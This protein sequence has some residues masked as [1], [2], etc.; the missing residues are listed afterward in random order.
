MRDDLSALFVPDG[1]RDPLKAARRDMKR[2]LPKRFYADA[3]VAPV[4]EGFAI[5]LDGK[6]VHTP[7]RKKLAVPAR[8]LA[9]ALAAEWRGQGDEIDPATMPK[10]RLV[11]SALD[12]VAREMDAVA[13]EVA[14]FAGSDLVCYR[15]A[16]PDSLVEAQNTAWNPVLDFFRER[17]GVRFVCSEGVT[18]VDQPQ[19]SLAAIQRAVAGFG[20]GDG[21]AIKLAALNVMTTLTGSALIALALAQGALSFDAAW[22]AA[23]VDEDFQMRLWGADDEA[24]AR[25]AA[26]K[27]DMRAAYEVFSA[28]EGEI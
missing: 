15:A 21:G 24:L 25:R 6:H 22:D 5:T 3:S 26:R 19:D 1:E 2:P 23:H 7:A 13:A 17:L 8:S 28:I 9:E 14:K 27:A 20:E 4:D 11:N 12:G 10:T 16:A 18:F